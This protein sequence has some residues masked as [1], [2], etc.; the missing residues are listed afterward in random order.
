MLFV[1][2]WKCAP[3]NLK[4]VVARFKQTGGTPPKGVKMIGRWH[5]VTQGRGV[6]VAE[7]D[8][9]EAIARWSYAWS[10]LLSFETYP[11]L[12]D[13]GAAKVFFE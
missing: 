3:E 12:D 9:A 10:D 7:A 5:D 13:A 4:S 1:T 2:H 8:D 11:V 6:T